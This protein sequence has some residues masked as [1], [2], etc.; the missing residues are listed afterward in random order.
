[1]NLIILGQLIVA[2]NA[3]V[4]K[5]APIIRALQKLR[6]DVGGDLPE[7]VVSLDLSDEVIDRTVAKGEQWLRDHPAPAPA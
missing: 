6:N 4:A 7:L 1:M 3:G 5:I 2:V